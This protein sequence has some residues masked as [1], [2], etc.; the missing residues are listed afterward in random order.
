VF[1]P[2]RNPEKNLKTRAQN[3]NTVL[4][5]TGDAFFAPRPLSPLAGRKLL[6][7]SI[8]K[9]AILTRGLCR[10]VGMA[11]PLDVVEV[12]EQLWVSSMRADMIAVGGRRDDAFALALDAQRVR[13][14]VRGTQP[15][16]CGAIAAGCA[17]RPAVGWSAGRSGR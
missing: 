2:G 1:L 11:K 14:Q 12:P 3:W 7:R 8:A 13:R 17:G 10:M 9:A 15:A 16:P 6:A 4:R 5:S